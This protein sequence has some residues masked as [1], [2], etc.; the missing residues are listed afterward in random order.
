MGLSPND[1]KPE[2]ITFK[3]AYVKIRKWYVA[4]ENLAIARGDDYGKKSAEL[5]NHLPKANTVTDL[6]MR[7]IMQEVINGYLEWA[8]HK[9]DGQFKMAA[10][11]HAAL[12][13]SNQWMMNETEKQEL[14]TSH[15]WRFLII[16]Q[17]IQINKNLTPP[18]WLL[19]ICSV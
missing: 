6:E 15:I 11:A 2:G 5:I 10:Y 14:K 1:K 7:A 19:C 3:D 8:Y 16:S 13:A 18:S 12:E 9:D 17:Q 4:N